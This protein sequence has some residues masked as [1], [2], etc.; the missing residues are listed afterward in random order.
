MRVSVVILF[1]M[2]FFGH[3]TGANVYDNN[4]NFI[5]FSDAVCVCVCVVQ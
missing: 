5:V 1:G 4:A 2:Q 3:F